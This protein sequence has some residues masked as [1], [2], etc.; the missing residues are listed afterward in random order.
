MLAFWGHFRDEHALPEDFTVQCSD[1]P[2]R[3]LH[4]DLLSDHCKS[5]HVNQNETFDTINPAKKRKI[6]AAKKEPSKQGNL[7]KDI[8]ISICGSKP[9]TVLLTTVLLKKNLY[10]NL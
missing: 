2:A 3:F 10:L 4:T 5:E 9:K 7:L 6:S 8:V 1:C